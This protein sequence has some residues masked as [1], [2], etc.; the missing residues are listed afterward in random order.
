MER[1]TL[2]IADDIRINRKLLKVIFN[3]Q[4]EILEA[5]DGEETIK[6]LEENSDKIALLFLDLQNQRQAT[7]RD[8]PCRGHQVAGRHAH[9]HPQG[10]LVTRDLRH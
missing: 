1:N 9:L 6:M 10:G 8:G 5:Q 7:R 3:E 4:Y 2:L